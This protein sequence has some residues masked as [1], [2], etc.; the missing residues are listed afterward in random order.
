[1]ARLIMSIC[2]RCGQSFLTGKQ[3]TAK[4]CS[5][6]CFYGSPEERF[7]RYTDKTPGNGPNGDCWFWTKTFTTHGYGQFSID[8]KTVKAH[9]YSYKRYK[10][11]IPKGMCVC[12]SCDTPKC[13]NPNHLWL[14]T[15]RDNLQDCQDKGRRRGP[16]GE[17][18]P[19]AK[20]TDD[21]VIKI[22]SDPRMHKLIAEDYGVH[23][24]LIGSIKSG[25]IWKHLP[26]M[27]G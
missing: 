11:D 14:G 13:V 23:P 19:K 16:A 8:N 10:G 20:L 15:R 4:F 3:Y 26:P 22:R 9:I 12:H 24:S 25:K 7:D 17:A 27:S 21:D 5:R 18:H 1:M 2:E 6:V